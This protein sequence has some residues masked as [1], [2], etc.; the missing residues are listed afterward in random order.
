M[1]KLDGTLQQKLDT[2]MDVE[3]TTITPPA[4]A[5]AAASAE[6][7]YNGKSSVVDVENCESTATKIEAASG[8]ARLSLTEQKEEKIVEPQPQEEEIWFSQG[9]GMV[10]IAG[11]PGEPVDV[12]ARGS[13]TGTRQDCTP[14]NLELLY[15]PPHWG[16]GV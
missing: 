7:D 1:L 12:S 15:V 9:S 13:V 5:N 14:E 8:T 6:D 11:S 16:E 3:M 10:G 2:T 4:V